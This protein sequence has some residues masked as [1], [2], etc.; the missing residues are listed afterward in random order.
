VEYKQSQTQAYYQRLFE[1]ETEN[2]SYSIETP[3][4]VTRL[5]DSAWLPQGQ[6]NVGAEWQLTPGFAL[7]AETGVRLQ[8]ARKYS[9]YTNTAGEL[10]EGG[11][12]DVNVSIPVTLRGSINF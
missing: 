3:D 7:A 1:G 5:Y 10:I 8:G 9:D 6:L 11:K 12:G 2:L 4:T